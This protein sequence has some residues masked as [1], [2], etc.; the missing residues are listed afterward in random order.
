M[1]ANSSRFNRFLGLL[2]GQF[3]TLTVAHSQVFELSE[4]DLSWLGERVF[5]NECAAKFDCLTSWNEGED[6][7]SLG[8]GHFI[9]FPEGQESPFEETFPALLAAF[10]ADNIV[11]PAWIK[12][13]SEVAE[14]DAPWDSRDQFYAT[15]NSVKSTELRNFLANTKPEQVNFIV[16][17]LSRELDNIIA[18]FPSDQQTT[19]RHK[20]SVLANSLPPY[21]PYALID[22]VHFKGT[23]LSNSERYENQGWGLQQVLQEMENSPTTLYSFV[24]AAKRTLSTRVANAPKERNEQR[25]LAGW[26]KRVETYLPPQ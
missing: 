10:E 25:W 4:S 13:N 5:A 23:G 3:A 16:R 20:L 22:Y 26:H 15:F 6:F 17:R 24:Q 11:L 9:W 2:L 1:L 8:I 7:P 12:S 14:S 21:G 19:V 18:A